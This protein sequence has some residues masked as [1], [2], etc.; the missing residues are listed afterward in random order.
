VVLGRWLARALCV[1]AFVLATGAVAPGVA[2]A[3][4]VSLSDPGIY[5]VGQVDVTVARTGSGSFT[6]RV[7]YPAT[8]AGT[9]TPINFNGAPYAAIT[10]GHGYQ[11][12]VDTYAST[13]QHLASWG[14]I[15]IAARSYESSLF[16]DHSRFADDLRD[17]LTYLTSENDLPASRFF[18]AVNTARYGASGHSMGG[19]ASLL[20]AS[21]DER[22]LAVSNLAA[23]ETSPS[24]IAA[25]ASIRRPVQ[26][27]AG[28]QDTIAA[29]GD[30]QTPMYNNGS[31]PRQAPLIVGGW[32]CGFQDYS[33]FGLFCDS[34]SIPQATQRS[35]T[36][37]MLA[38]W[39]LLYLRGDAAR[40]ED[41]WGP[42]A[43]N[44]AQVAYTGDAGISLAPGTQAGATRVNL[45]ITYTV[46]LQNTGPLT[47]SYGIGVQ[48]SWVATPSLTQTTGLPPG[49]TIPLEIVV[50]PLDTGRGVV[51]FTA[52]SLFDAGTTIWG[53]LVTTSTQ[54]VANVFVPVAGQ[55]APR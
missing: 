53:T 54:L 18:G 41:I 31:A 5:A 44:D 27:I 36:R 35:L 32:H 48:S 25:M 23:A 42:A 50:L 3:A 24:A 51:T 21:R 37:R 9:E 12:S 28:S 13:L 34:G 39:F 14:F 40:W 17:S 16:P 4:S 38:A 15:V 1:V 49:T 7:Y 2:S 47:V 8:S 33:N 43:Q 45:P 52:R 22:I 19:G 20:A 46:A 29:P 6:A 11:Q 30:N 10:F 26:L 55:S